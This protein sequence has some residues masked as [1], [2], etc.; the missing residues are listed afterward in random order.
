VD[1]SVVIG[2]V[3]S[4]RSIRAALVAMQQAVNEI[5]AE[6]IVVDAS[7]D[8]SADIAEE[9]LGPTAVIRCPVGT[10]TPDLWAEGIRRSSGRMV[11]LTTGHFVVPPMWARELVAGVEAGATGAGGTFAVAA[12]T[13]ATDWAVF[14]LRYSE[15]LVEP[16]SARRGLTNIPADNAAYEGEALRQHVATTGDGF[17]EVE[18]H[19]RLQAAG[20]TLVLVPNAAAVYGQS[21]PLATIIRHRFRHGRHAGAW[22]AATRQRSGWL[23][24]AT[25]P[26]V[27]AAL[28]ARAWRRVRGMPEHRRRFL[29]SIPQFVVLACVWAAGEALGAIAGPAGRQSSLLPA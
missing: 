17:W 1:V 20:G 13:S 24:V 11:A 28:V 7:S 18:F 10:L 23:L 29:R 25:S 21:F 15:F 8:K 16:S 19:R 26:L 3:E 27:P 22:R 12:E 9:L 5:E 2:S 6:V 14:Y 4:E